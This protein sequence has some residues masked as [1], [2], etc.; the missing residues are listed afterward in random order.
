MTTCFGKEYVFG[1]PCMSF[2]N[3]YNLCVYFFLLGFVAW[4]VGFN[5]FIYET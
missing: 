4:G 1:V 3:G 2:V 5:F